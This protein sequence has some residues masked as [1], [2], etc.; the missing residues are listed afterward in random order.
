M[1]SRR[2][3]FLWTI[4]PCLDSLKRSKPIHRGKTKLLPTLKRKLLIYV[5]VLVSQIDIYVTFGVIGVNKILAGN[6]TSGWIPVW[7]GTYPG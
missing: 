2:L 4:N 1:G 3:P 6:S 7:N 5:P